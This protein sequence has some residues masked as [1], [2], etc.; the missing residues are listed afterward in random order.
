M[1]VPESSLTRRV[2]CRACLC[3][4][5]PVSLSARVEPAPGGLAPRAG[6]QGAALE[7][8]DELWQAEKWG[9]DAEAI[10][11]REARRADFDAAART[12][13]LL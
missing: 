10:A 9:D 12:L 13:T 3:F 11:A 7:R 4:S 1:R 8:L 2:P 6:V 5:V